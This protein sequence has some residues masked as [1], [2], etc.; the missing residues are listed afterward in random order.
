MET[1]AIKARINELE[2]EI[3][4]FKKYGSEVPGGLQKELDNLRENYANTEIIEKIIPRFQQFLWELNEKYVFQND[5]S[6]LINYGKNNGFEILFDNQIYQPLKL[7]NKEINRRKTAKSTRKIEDERPVRK[8]KTVRATREKI[9]VTFPDKTVIEGNNVTETY[10]TCINKIGLNK[11]I[12]INIYRYGIPL[13]SETKNN[14]YTQKNVSGYW[15]MTQLSTNAKLAILKE[16]NKSLN[17]N[18]K[19]RTY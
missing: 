10:F 17:L 18:L 6:F 9:S 16:I 8:I 1:I 11:I 4:V 3:E 5:F 7:E 2:R 13:I 19:I 12:P 14:F 15:I